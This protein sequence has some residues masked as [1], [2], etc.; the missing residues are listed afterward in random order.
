MRSIGRSAGP[1]VSPIEP[2]RSMT[3]TTLSG[4]TRSDSTSGACT[5]TRS[6]TRSGSLNGDGAAS[7]VMLNSSISGWYPPSK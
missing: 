5:P 6:I 4:M 3:S 7:I 1:A 2:E